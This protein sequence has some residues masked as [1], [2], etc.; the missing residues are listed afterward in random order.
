[1]GKFNYSGVIVRKDDVGYGILSR[2]RLISVVIAAFPDRTY[3]FLSSAQVTDLISENTNRLLDA[4]ASS[5]H[6]QAFKLYCENVAQRFVPEM[7]AYIRGLPTLHRAAETETECVENA[8]RNA[9]KQKDAFRAAVS[10]E[11]CIPYLLADEQLVGSM[12]DVLREVHKGYDPLYWLKE[13]AIAAET[14]LMSKNS[15][16]SGM[17]RQY[18]QSDEAVKE[19]VYV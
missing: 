1:M 15:S 9:L 4:A 16:I 7:I 14:D 8:L 2:E 3:H 19:T 5:H 13:A 17:I 6:N 18:R 10:F 12:R 11:T